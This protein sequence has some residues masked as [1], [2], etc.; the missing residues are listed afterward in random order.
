[1]KRV[2]VKC[3][4]YQ[5]TII[6]SGFLSWANIHNIKLNDGGDIVTLI[7]VVVAN[8]KLSTFTKIIN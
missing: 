1:M 7:N 3:S 2:C 5:L 4:D 8:S 6:F